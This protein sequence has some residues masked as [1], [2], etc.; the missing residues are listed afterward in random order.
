MQL[1]RMISSVEHKCKS[2]YNMEDVL[3]DKACDLTKQ[4]RH[5]PS[6]LCELPDDALS[7]VFNILMNPNLDRT[8]SGAFE[9]LQI[10]LRRCE[11]VFQT[12]RNGSS[13]APVSNQPDT[14]NSL[15]KGA[16]LL[17]EYLSVSK[18]SQAVEES[19]DDDLRVVQHD[20]LILRKIALL[21]RKLLSSNLPTECQVPRAMV[22][23]G[24]LGIGEI[25]IWIDL[26]LRKHGLG[27]DID[28]LLS[29]CFIKVQTAFDRKFR[30]ESS[31]IGKKQMR[32]ARPPDR[33]V[34]L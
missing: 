20:L 26:S 19:N 15:M 8:D 23:R 14:I 27:R 1:E 2:D 11:Q 21:F 3:Y 12:G 4:L 22:L 34:G 7:L 18:I 16:A 9:S 5:E 6:P 17:K 10:W 33:S 32:H 25:A 29:E 24:V 31:E 30:D 28:A 13:E